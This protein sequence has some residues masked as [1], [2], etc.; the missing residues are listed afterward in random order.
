MKQKLNKGS[1]AKIKK[2]MAKTERKTSVNVLGTKRACS[3]S[4]ITAQQAEK[5]M[6]RKQENTGVRP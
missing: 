6:G 1:D 5:M 3:R 4:K 2:K